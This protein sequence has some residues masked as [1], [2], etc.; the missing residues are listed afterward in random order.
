MRRSYPTHTNRIIFTVSGNGRTM[1]GS[2]SSVSH[3]VCRYRANRS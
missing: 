3:G 1:Q 2:E